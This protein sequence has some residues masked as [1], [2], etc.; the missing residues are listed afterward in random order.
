M[1]QEDNKDE[2]LSKKEFLEASM[3]AYGREERPV[4]EFALC[5]IFRKAIDLAKESQ[6]FNKED[7]DLVLGV[8]RNIFHHNPILKARLGDSPDIDLNRYAQAIVRRAFIPLMLLEDVDLVRC[9]LEANPE[10]VN[11]AFNPAAMDHVDGEI[12]LSKGATIFQKYL[13]CPGAE[14]ISQCFLESL[15]DSELLGREGLMRY[16]N[17]DRTE[18]IINSIVNIPQESDDLRNRLV[19]I[20]KRNHLEFF[21]GYRTSADNGSV[22]RELDKIL[23]PPTQIG[24]S[25]AEPLVSSQ[26]QLGKG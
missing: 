9:A 18:A 7:R 11:D 3:V 16:G 23:S 21:E 13:N 26:A 14:D 17:R 10:L 4:I 12:S 1:M 2:N 22:T 8:M 20:L 6:D 15:R 24:I 25:G 5:D 19:G